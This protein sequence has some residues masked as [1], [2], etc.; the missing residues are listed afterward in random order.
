MIVVCAYHSMVEQ[1]SVLSSASVYL[2]RLNVTCDE[3]FESAHRALTGT[4][5]C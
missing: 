4:R 3:A 1:Y 5:R 2:N